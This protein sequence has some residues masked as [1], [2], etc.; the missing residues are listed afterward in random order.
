MKAVLSY[1]TG[2]ASMEDIMRVYPRHKAYLEDFKKSYTVVGI[3][4]FKDRK[5]SMAIFLDVATAE[6]F[7]MNDPFVLEGIAK[8]IKIREWED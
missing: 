6:K 2:S 4:P 3:G 5:G 7:R 8:D 1:E